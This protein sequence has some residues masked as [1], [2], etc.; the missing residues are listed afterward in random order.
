MTT[1]QLQDTQI[2]SRYGFS[3]H[4]A[5]SLSDEEQ[6][7]VEIPVFDNAWSNTNKKQIGTKKVRV[8]KL[9][10]DDQ[11]GQVQL[12]SINYRGFCKDGSLRVRDEYEYRANG[13]Y[14]SQME[15][16]N[17]L[18]QAIPTHYHDYAITEFN[19]LMGEALHEVTTIQKNGVVI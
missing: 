16:W 8:E 7:I 19:K 3:I 6:F 1:I 4:I 5:V 2:N 17:T 18:L 13:M 11:D 10:Y 12:R 15:V 14:Y 9:T